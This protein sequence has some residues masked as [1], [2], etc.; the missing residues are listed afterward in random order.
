MLYMIHLLFTQVFL[1]IWISG[2]YPPAASNNGLIIDG[3]M[4]AVTGAVPARGWFRREI[5]PPGVTA[6][7][8][9]SRHFMVILQGSSLSVSR[10]KLIYAYVRNVYHWKDYKSRNHHSSSVNDRLIR[11]QSG[12]HSHH[13]V[14]DCF[15]L[16][17]SHVDKKRCWFRRKMNTNYLLL[18][19][20]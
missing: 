17:L 14:T 8:G 11:C 19:P 15:F 7:T 12:F 10:V 9:V 16:L 6:E 4:W 2:K 20:S 5:T 1:P 3:A 13:C 18:I